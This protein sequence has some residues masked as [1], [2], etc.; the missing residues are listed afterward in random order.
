MRKLMWFALGFGAA[1]AVGAYLGDGYLQAAALVGL[2]LIIA[3]IGLIKRWKP[4]RFVL[5]I[6]SGVLAGAMAFLLYQ[7][8]YLAPAI[9]VD[10]NT[11]EI[12]AEVTD[13]SYDTDYGS[14][15]EGKLIL[16]GRQYPVV[17]YIN[18]KKN[19]I[20]GDVVR[21]EFRLRCTSGGDEAPTYH[22]GNG[23]VLLCYPKSETTFEETQTIPDQYFPAVLRRRLLVTLDRMF[24][25]D[26][27][28][29]AKALL[30]GDRTDVDYETNTAFKVSGISHIIAVS[31]LHVSIL[32]AVVA[33]L[34]GRKRL[35][36]VLLGIPVLFAFAAIAG[37]TPSVTRACL[38]QS[39]MLLGLLF[40]KEYDP[41]TSLAFAALAMLAVNPM[42]IT[43]VSFQLS[44]G[45]MAGI[46][47]F[48]N[49]IT[50][51]VNGFSFWKDW[52]GK[53]LRVR[54][55]SWISGGV[56]VTLSA[57]FFTTPLVA[58]YFGAVSLIGIVTNLLTLWAVSICF[59]GIMA[60]CIAS[61]IWTNAGAALAW[62]ISWLI[63]YVLAAA[64]L[65]AAFPLAAVYTKS[66]Y[67]VLWMILCY[68]LITV[69]L[70]AKNRQPFVLICCGVCGLCLALTLSWL[71]PWTDNVRMTVLD[72][73]QGQCIL[74]QA[75]GKTV[76]VDCGGDSDTGAADLAAETLLSQ[77][78]TRLDAVIVT[79]YDRDHAGGVGYL[80]SR[81]PADTVFLP[82]SPDEDDILDSIIPYCA[83]AELFVNKDMVV[84][85]EGTSINVFAPILASSDNERGLCV[86]FRNEN[87]DILIT[88]DLN[89]LGEKLLLMEKN[90]PDLTALVVGHHGSK[91]ST[92]QQLLD[93]TAPEYAL[94]SVGKDNYY[95]HPNS[96]VLE[97]LLQSG[98]AV[99]RTDE[100]GTII[101]RR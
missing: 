76:L 82:D 53:S 37:F 39:L 60:V 89:S 72:V 84:S 96:T 86:L 44:V 9:D 23:T 100:H 65:M 12:S 78:I 54:I 83:G 40:N 77:G 34:C 92:C 52:K 85:W 97:R 2:A 41:P 57:M 21:G 95:G 48:S 98:C 6:A 26:T 58:Y 62:C 4:V 24:P 45:C 51:W 91:S 35:L 13:Y 20:P 27:A 49:R 32:F 70:A 93:A 80:L 101:F 47:L 15:A 66:I 29:F 94:I 64:K 69:F 87:C 28:F 36:M 22:R 71:E 38:M 74:L 25:E 88:G 67:I 5:V 31:G 1:C 68:G 3:F 55:R 75:D 30:L 33:L 79:H 61:A 43:S 8:V 18:E 63:R 99:Y 90:I 14:A 50:V 73:G 56:G 19:L 10:G 42:V 59:Y 16:D 81:V 11:V 17:L 46:F 7:E